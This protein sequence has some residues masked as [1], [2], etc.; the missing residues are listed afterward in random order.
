[1][2]FALSISVHADTAGMILTLTSMSFREDTKEDSCVRYSEDAL[3]KWHISTVKKHRY[4]L[5]F[6]HCRRSSKG[7]A[8]KQILIFYSNATEL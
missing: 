4:F 1:M 6:V 3:Y 7:I 5:L 8:E 2:T